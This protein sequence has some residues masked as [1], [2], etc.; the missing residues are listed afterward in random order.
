MLT[1]AQQ[2]AREFKTTAS[3]APIIMAGDAAAI[4][5]LHRERTGEIEPEDLSH[6]YPAQLGNHV[7]GFNLDWHERKTGMELTERGVFFPHPSLHNIGA[8]LDAYRC[9]DDTVIE[10][11]AIG[12]WRRLDE[13]IGY[14]TPQV[15]VQMRCRQASKGALLISHGGGEPQEIAVTPDPSYEQVLWERM[16][17]FELCV[18]TLTLP[19]PLPRIVP[20]EQWR[21]IDLDSLAE[22]W[23]NWAHELAF[24]LERWRDVR[25]IAQEF[26]EI[27]SHIKSLFPDDAGR[28]TYAGIAIRRNRRGALTIKDVNE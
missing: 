7:E 26:E 4:V 28:L 12:A 16:C 5:R 17:A 2:R 9:H 23:P 20:P 18:Q 10:A 24:D 11:K 14:Y 15:I 19:A 3:Q 1:A 8:T 22:P 21:S 6:A 27:T 25:P 13:A